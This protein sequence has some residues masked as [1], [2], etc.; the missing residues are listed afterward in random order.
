MIRIEI[1]RND[2]VMFFHASYWSGKHNNITGPIRGM[3][4]HIQRST[5]VSCLLISILGKSIFFWSHPNNGTSRAVH[6]YETVGFKALNIT[7]CS[8]Y[9]GWVH[10]SKS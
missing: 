9:K 7:W 5:A 4:K 2:T 3:E 8:K 10:F 1:M 6:I